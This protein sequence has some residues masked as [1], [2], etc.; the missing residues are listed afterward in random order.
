MAVTES[1]LEAKK[2]RVAQSMQS[3]EEKIAALN[4][5]C[6]QKVKDIQEK[7]KKE[8]ESVKAKFK[9]QTDALKDKNKDLQKQWDE[10][11]S[12]RVKVHGKSV[13]DL[14]NQFVSDDVDVSLVAE[15][16]KSKG[17]EFESFLKQMGTEEEEPVE[18]ESSAEEPEE[19]ATAEPDE[20]SS[21][22]SGYSGYGY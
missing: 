2:D 15:F 4:E 16:L 10:L 5:Q 11:E 9:E 6:D 20:T 12:E 8:I 3:N 14:F 22:D 19:D 1:A 18:E 13:G 21:S 17:G 7:R